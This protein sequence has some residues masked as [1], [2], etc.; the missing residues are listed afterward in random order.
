[1]PGP[2]LRSAPF[3]G[4]IGLSEA[5]LIGLLDQRIE[6][7][8]EDHGYIAIGHCVP[9]QVSRSIELGFGL[10]AEG[11]LDQI[12]LR[13]QHQDLRR[14]SSRSASSNGS[15]PRGGSVVIV[16]TRS[17]PSKK[18]RSPGPQL[19]G[20]IANGAPTASLEPASL[21]PATGQANDPWPR[22]PPNR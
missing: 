22:Q 17:A 11:R 5:P 2:L 18:R 8:L 20:G 12:T 9:Q 3:S 10:L 4:R 1:M 6:R 13:R 21:G 14:A 15:P 7:S 16:G 19:T